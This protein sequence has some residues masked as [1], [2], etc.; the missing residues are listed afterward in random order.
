MKFTDIVFTANQNLW[1]NKLRSVLTILAV[2][3][4][5]FTI[6]MTS[7]INTGVNQ[8]I[9]KQLASVGGDD[10]IQIISAEGG[11]ASMMSMGGGTGRLTGNLDGPTEYNP[12]KSLSLAPITDED[13][14]KMRQIFGIRSVDVYFDVTTEY[15]RGVENDKKFNIS[16]SEIPADSYKIDM[17]AG[18]LPTTDASQRQIALPP[19]YATALGYYSDKAIVGEKVKIGVKNQASDKIKEVEAVVVGVQNRSIISMSGAWANP[20]LNDALYEALTAGMP[21]Q[22]RN[23][24]FAAIAVLL[25]DDE[26]TIANVKAGLEEIGFIG[27]TNE[28]GIAMLKAFFDAITTVLIMFGV[29]ALLAAVIGIINTLFMAVQERTRE[30]GIMKAVGMAPSSI[31]VIF[32][33]EAILLGFWGSLVGI[34]VAFIAGYVANMAAA[35]TFLASLPGFTL[36]IFDPFNLVIFVLLIMLVAF[37]AGALPARRASRLDPIDALRYE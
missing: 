15:I 18:R 19:D 36:V 32:S 31:K 25:D 4:G 22:Y 14:A 10:T 20:S 9:D 26:D 37:L 8:Y 17:I 1:R 16:V 2:F 21:E 23:K 11:L 13:L 35:E 7:A 34:V 3:I 12:D 29:I 24:A 28:D 30:I 5:A 33:L 27:L 6:V